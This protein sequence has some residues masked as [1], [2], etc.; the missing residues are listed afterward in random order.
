MKTLIFL[1]TAIPLFGINITTTSWYGEETQG[2]MANGQ[3]F[4]P[5]AYTCASWD[6]P[7]GTLLLVRELQS[8]R[9]VVVEVTDRGPNKRLYK[10][11]R[12]LDL[13]RKAFARLGSLDRGLLRVEIVTAIIPVK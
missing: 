2:Y 7:F 12:K 13:S 4:D 11:G 8:N 10:A 5:E 3:W 6:Y 9:K 1:L